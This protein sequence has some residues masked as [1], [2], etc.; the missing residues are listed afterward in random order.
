MWA[1]ACSPVV[2][3]LHSSY[4]YRCSVFR[5]RT[6]WIVWLSAF[7]WPASNKT[8]WSV[9]VIDVLRA[10]LFTISAVHTSQNDKWHNLTSFLQIKKALLNVCRVRILV[11]QLLNAGWKFT[12]K[13]NQHALVASGA[14]ARCVRRS[15]ARVRDGPRA[16]DSAGTQVCVSF[17][18]LFSLSIQSFF[19]TINTNE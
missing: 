16:G 14:G 11:N 3:F 18:F 10:Q 13:L 19:H 5:T 7:L 9:L 1:G 8:K 15:A 17:S 12:A 6:T 4:I 2:L